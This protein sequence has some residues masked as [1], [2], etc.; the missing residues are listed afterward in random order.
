VSRAWTR[1]DLR[2]WIRFGS[3]SPLYVSLVEL[4]GNDPELLDL[5]NR[6]EHTPRPN[7]LLAGVQYLLMQSPD[8]PLA[9]HYPNI[10][11]PTEPGGKLEDRFK[12]FLRRHEEE[13]VEIGRTR[14]TQTNECRRCA[15]LLPVIWLTPLTRFHLLDVGSSAGLNLNL[16]RYHYGWGELEWG[17]QSTVNLETENRGA[18]LGPRAIEM[19]SRVG[20][21]LNPIDAADRDDRL[22]LESL[23][24]PEHF[25]RRR[26]LN[27]ALELATRYPVDIVGGD[28]L[29]TM[30]PL[31]EALPSGEPAIV[32]HSFALLQF[33]RE[34][35][36]SFR[37]ILRRQRGN[38]P[39]YEISFDAFGRE[40]G[41]G[42]LT[43]DDGTGPTDVG[44]AHPHGEWLE[45]YARP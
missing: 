25:E 14:Y 17:P 21:D 34:A 1:D 27:E 19:A 15:V 6:I 13:L 41:V 28:A 36:E 9:E 43:I 3:S 42:G 8:D 33:S 5:L 10:G 24:W 31:L 45:L 12:D 7:V 20:L 11:E 38:R 16:D 30:E 29:E 40:D 23:V 18:D 39:V 32:M 4:I 26:R 35:R 44:T 2:T 22:W 37:E